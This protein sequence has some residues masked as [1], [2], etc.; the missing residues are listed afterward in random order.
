MITNYVLSLPQ[1]TDDPT[2]SSSEFFDLW[3]DMDHIGGEFLVLR[4]EEC[5]FYFLCTEDCDI[6]GLCR[7]YDWYIVSGDR[8]NDRLKIGMGLAGSDKYDG[9]L[10]RVEDEDTLGMWRDILRFVFMSDFV[11]SFYPL[12]NRFRGNLRIDGAPCF[13]I[14][15]YYP[16]THNAKPTAG[17]KKTVN[18][19]HRFKEGACAA[20]AAKIFSL[21]ILRM[22][23][24]GELPNPVVVPV[25]ASTRERHQRRFA[26][27]CLHL[28][29]RLGVEDGFRAVWIEEDREQQ[30]G[31]TGP[32]S[33]DGVKFNKKYVAGKDILLVDDILTTGG[34]FTA[35]KRRLEK[36]GAASVTG[37]FLGR[38]V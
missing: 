23:W 28:S 25:P 24:F 26:S 19:I 32:R 27:F 17:Q 15:D 38:T 30:K 31:S 9:E 3:K 16:V 11:R 10:F 34:T 14:H 4:T 2:F 22:A 5:Y 20:L 21:A 13:Y 7:A 35:V 18:L 29:H 33:L 36:A 8:F 6:E 37:I 1:D 12:D